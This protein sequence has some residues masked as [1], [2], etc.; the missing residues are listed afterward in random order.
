MW[1]AWQQ[2]GRCGLQE[3]LPNTFPSPKPFQA[4][5]PGGNK[6][7][8]IAHLSCLLWLWTFSHPE[9]KVRDLHWPECIISSAWESR[10]R[11]ID[12]RQ[13]RHSSSCWHYQI[14]NLSRASHLL[15]HV[16]LCPKMLRSRILQICRTY[17]SWGAREKRLLLHPS[18]EEPDWSLSFLDIERPLPKRRSFDWRQQSRFLS[19]S[20]PIPKHKIANCKAS[21]HCSCSLRQTRILRHNARDLGCRRFVYRGQDW[22]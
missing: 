20:H 15:W 6:W 18:C 19:Q 5:T 17:W 3:L 21:S 7:K 16:P 12:L 14:R 10:Y 8:D 2:V 11:R 13:T 22:C 9:S 4:F 1:E